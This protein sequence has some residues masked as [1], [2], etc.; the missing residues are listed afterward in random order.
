LL[1]D[2]L[3]AAREVSQ[4]TASQY[5]SMFDPLTPLSLAKKSIP[6][7][8]QDDRSFDQLITAELV[9]SRQIISSIRDAQDAAAT[10][11]LLFD[12]LITQGI[13]GRDFMRRLE[14][15]KEQPLLCLEVK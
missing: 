13:P 7:Y 5:N 15:E 1:A 11:P 2:E 14:D 12:T 8:D 6:E 9:S 3:P 10:R 4:A